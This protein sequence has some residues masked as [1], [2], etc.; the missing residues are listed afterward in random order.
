[1]IV[2][3]MWCVVCGVWCVVFGVV[4]LYMLLGVGLSSRLDSVGFAVLTSHC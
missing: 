3:C 2:H 4:V 1:M